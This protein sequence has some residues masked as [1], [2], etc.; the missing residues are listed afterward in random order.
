MQSQGMKP[1]RLHDRRLGYVLKHVQHRLRTLMDARLAEVDL[2]TSQYAALMVV[3]RDGGISNAELARRCF[4]TP[5]TMHRIVER[6]E[7]AEF[8]ERS[9]HPDHGR[10]KELDL[11][12]EGRTRVTEAHEVVS[13]IEATMTSDLSP[14]DVVQ[15]KTLLIR[16]AD[17]LDQA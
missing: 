1:Q 5:Q 17:N 8:I 6:L 10:I 11:T 7:E 4:V 12:E 3:E 15:V 2:T 13:E 16:C 14:D 9:P